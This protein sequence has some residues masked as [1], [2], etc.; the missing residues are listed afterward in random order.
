MNV[1]R[2]SCFC[3]T[4][5]FLAFVPSARAQAQAASP[6]TLG[7]VV[8]MPVVE[9]S[10][11]RVGD[12]PVVAVSRLGRAQLRDLN[13]GQDTPMA[14]A[15]LP[16]AYAWSDA[17]NG[18]G[19][20]Y[21]T[22]R[23]FPQRRISV[24]VN[25]VPLN[26][27]ES[28]EVYWID[29]PDL[30]SATSEVQVQR[31]VGSALYG[32]AAL[33]G[34]VNVETSPFGV[35]PHASVL[36][37]GGSFG[38]RRMMFE[39]GSGPIRD[40]W[41]LYGRYAR[42]ESDGYRDQSWSKLWSY[43]ISARRVVGRHVFR[44]NLYGGPEETHLAYLALSPEYLNGG[45]T[46]DADRDRRF[47]PLTYDGERDHFFEP[48]YEF[49]HAWAP[50]PALALTGTWFWFDGRGY[51]EE[52]RTNRALAD[53]RLPGIATTD[54][55]LYSR[56]HYAQDANGVL[57]RDAQGRATLVR[58][59]V[60]RRREVINR[61]YGWLPRARWA[62][63]GGALTVGGELR[64]HDGRH[65]GSVIAGDPLPTGTPNPSGY[66]DY[67]PRTM[68]AG[69]FARE[70]WDLSPE[71]RA[72]ADLA[73]RHASYA[74]RGDR[75]DG[76]GFDQRYDF[77]S[78][79]VAL[80]WAPTTRGQM[81]ASY[82]YS[83]REPAFRDLYDAEGVG[84]VPLYRRVDVAAGIYEDPLVRPEQVHDLELGGTWQASGVSLSANA[85]RMDFRDELVYAG[86]FNTDLGYPILGNAARSVHQG[87]ELAASAARRLARELELGFDGNATFSDNH[88]VTFRESYGP[89]PADQVVYDG[90]PLGFFPATMA[91]AAVRATWRSLGVRLE[92]QHAGRVYVDNTGDEANS[93]APRTVWN[94]VLSA[95]GR[96]AGTRAT[97][98]L[99]GLNLGDR[100]YATTG[101][102][103]YDRN[104]ALVPHV[105]PAATRSW[106]AEVRL[107]W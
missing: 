82:A 39:G 54:T 97:A 105:M 19:Y 12:R 31:G 26:D 44:A 33:G 81:F 38:T 107:D 5:A 76:I 80:S 57:L 8:P 75:Y 24:L 41:E 87:V 62:H 86:Q 98:T 18:I 60:T 91:N 25:G 94:A 79:R 102:M 16:G 70:E 29:H 58:F 15:T 9:V 56:D 100:Y 69:L 93:V 37:G 96:V 22:L 35:A 52:R 61:H 36:A 101:Y 63:A 53:Y 51:Y 83:S 7:R 3:M 49:I 99:R 88:F 73:W 106:L 2:R 30:L 74:M 67:H 55:T 10:T 78:P 72:T 66:Y 11:S 27:P 64:F 71:L 47:N 84:S 4:L 89:L 14:L 17:G 20:S 92:A 103:D 13:W 50:T 48:H 59:D 68:A 34:S 90:K 42:V 32:A 43:A 95:S 77:G 65:I 23:G 45:V 1:P 85:Y 21:L 6:D 104:G 28:H 40:G 46:G